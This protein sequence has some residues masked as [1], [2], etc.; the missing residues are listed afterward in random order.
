MISHMESKKTNNLTDTE[1]GA[2]G[3]SKIGEGGQIVQ[4]SSYEINKSWGC[5]A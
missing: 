3:L 4:T 5:N 2:W 1:V